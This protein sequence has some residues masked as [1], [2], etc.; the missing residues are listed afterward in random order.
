MFRIPTLFVFFFKLSILTCIAQSYEFRTYNEQDG[1]GNRYINTINQIVDG[2]L[3]IGTGEG[4]YLFDG[5]SF[6]PYHEIHGLA[7]ELITCS[8]QKKDGSIYFGHGNGDVTYFHNHQCEPIKLG[9]Y[10]SGKVTSISE[11][12]EGNIWFASQN[13]GLVKFSE[14]GSKHYK[15]GL[16]EYTIFCSYIDANNTIWLGTDLGLVKAN[17]NNKGEIEASMIDNGVLTNITHIMPS[18]RGIYYSTEDAGMFEYFY[19]N[20]HFEHLP[21]LYNGLPLT[22]YKINSFNIDA[23]GSI[24]LCTN[25]HGLL[26]LQQRSANNFAS[27]EFYNG[28]QREN[29]IATKTTFFDRE[30]NLWLGSIGEGLSKLKENFLASYSFG[31]DEQN[32]LQSL[33]SAHDTLFIG[34]KGE[35]ILCTGNANNRIA[36]FN[37]TN[38]I[39]NDY[40]TCIFEDLNKD[41]WFGTESSG[42]FCLRHK[43]KRAERIPLSKEFSLFRINDIAYLNKHLFLATDFGVFELENKQVIHHYSIESGLPGNVIKTIYVDSQ[44]RVWLGTISDI[45]PFIQ[46]NG[47]QAVDPNIGHAQLVVKCFA[48]DN[49][50]RLWIGT[51]GSG[52]IC[53]STNPALILNKSK[54]L[55]S[56]YCYSLLTDQKNQLWVSH[57]GSMSRIDLSTFEV[58]IYKNN[59][60]SGGAL[61]AN[62]SVECFNQNIF[63]A[64]SSGLL[65]YKPEKDILN[66]LEPVLTIRSVRISD[67]EYPTSGHIHLPYGDYKIDILFQGISLKSPEKVTYSFLMEAY[68][69]EWS[70]TTANNRALFNHLSPGTYVFRVKTFNGDGVGGESIL[71]YTITI[72]KP[73]W[74]TL[75]FYA[76]LAIVIFLTIRLIIYRR[77]RLLRRNQE[78]LKHALDLRT[79]EVV[80]QKELLEI[81]NKDITDSILYAKNIQTAM[82]PPKGFLKTFFSDAFVYFKPRD[83]VS[84]DFYWA[85]RYNSKIVVACA[86][87]TGHGVPGAFM[88]LIGSTLLKDSAQLSEVQSPKDLIMRLDDEI[89]TM[90]NKKIMNTQIHDGMDICIVD[91]DL[92]T[93]ILRVASANRPIFIRKRGEMIEIRGDRKAIG[94]AEDV[95]F[96]FTLHQITLEK[97]DTFY[98]FSDGIPDQFGGPN[99][100][101]LK[102]KGLLDFINAHAHLPLAEQRR[103][104]KAFINDWK[105]DLDQLDDMILLACQI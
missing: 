45:V 64:T 31:E 104:F 13:S 101:K 33:F 96:E 41:I 3:V 99:E 34:N 49:Q 40:V 57:R 35:I 74:M 92:D 29:P 94:A 22:N 18:S 59:S 86:D 54:G 8:Y 58:N 83:I 1:L 53:I 44:S 71:T 25:N 67:V 39:P 80:E 28:N 100:K 32:N 21:I 69:N 30:G 68:D 55:E 97:G 85:N 24:W 102:K 90:L 16:E 77:E 38:G 60:S 43:T 79:R 20:N 47:I 103:H 105:G 91:F 26:E 51:E 42:F 93:G 10:F 63:F 12:K 37:K 15:T 88:S 98:M 84:G 72:E 17:I 95:Q 66:K 19:S 70:D 46:N 6:S 14:N 9:Q 11:D 50:H 82:L 62:G 89:K 78:R 52:L 5:F 36:T 48:E 2:S 75:W 87:C 81:K 7:N 4:L 61:Q 27:I 73:F 76:L 23:Q 56:D 65:R